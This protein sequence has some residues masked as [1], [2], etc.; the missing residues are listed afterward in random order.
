MA[1][2]AKSMTEA[3]SPTNLAIT[4]PEVIKRAVETRGESLLKGLRHMLAD[5][6]RG[7]LSHV[8]PDAFEFGVNIATT[9]GKV[10]HETGLYQLIHYAQATQDVLTVPLVIFPPWINRFYTLNLNPPYSEER[11]LGKEG[12]S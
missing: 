9:P 12:V 3:L 11:R 6:S 8:D 1:F 5:L 10:I 4:N 2:A 7:Q